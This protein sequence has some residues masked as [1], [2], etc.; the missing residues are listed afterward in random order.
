MNNLYLCSFASS[1]LKKSMYRFIEQSNDMGIY[2]DI[3]VFTFEDLSEKKNYK[4]KNL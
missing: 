3:K 1:D 2:K 4:F